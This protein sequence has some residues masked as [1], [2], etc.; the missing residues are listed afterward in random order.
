[1]QNKTIEWI[2]LVTDK[3]EESRN[4]YKNTLGLEIIREVPAEHFSQFAMENCNLAI[5]G[6]NELEALVGENH[7]GN[8]GGAIYTFAETSDVDGLYQLLADQGVEF[9]KEPKTQ[10]WGQRTAYFTDPDGHIWEIQQW[11]E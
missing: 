10:S 8:H 5:Y 3:F 1:M 4:F 7:I 9:I 2:I 11:V 6:R